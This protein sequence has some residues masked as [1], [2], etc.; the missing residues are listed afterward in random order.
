MKYI[1]QEHIEEKQQEEQRLQE[2][3]DSHNEKTT[4]L[5]ESSVV[6]E[7]NICSFM[8]KQRLWKVNNDKKPY[9]YFPE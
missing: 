3:A 9:D 4:E 8:R 6:D 5:C 7:T 2:E 1:F